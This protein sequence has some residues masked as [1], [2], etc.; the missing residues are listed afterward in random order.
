MC[1]EIMQ[2]VTG[3]HLRGEP[4]VLGGYSRRQVKGEHF[5]ALLPE[6]GAVV[7]GIVYQ[8]VT[9]SAWALLDR[10][11]GDFYVLTPVWV[12]LQDESVISASTYVVQ[13]HFRELLDRSGWDFNDFIDNAKADFLR[14]Y[15]TDP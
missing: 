6:V 1:P 5:P 3:C 9:A 11:E 4:C 7:E 2:E 8:D 10:Y 12:T 14:S 15:R 13:H